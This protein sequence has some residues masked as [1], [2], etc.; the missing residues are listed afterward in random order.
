[1]AQESLLAKFFG[2]SFNRCLPVG[3]SSAAKPYRNIL[4]KPNLAFMEQLF[5]VHRQLL[6]AEGKDTLDKAIDPHSNREARFISLAH[7]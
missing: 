1:V 2:R 7:L 3:R 4:T 6:R 5:E